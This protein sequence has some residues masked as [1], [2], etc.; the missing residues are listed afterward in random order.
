MVGPLLGLPWALEALG[1]LGAG[2]TVATGNELYKGYQNNEKD[3]QDR[4]NAKSYDQK[5]AEAKANAR[6][7]TFNEWTSNPANA[8]ADPAPYGRNMIG[9]PK[10]NPRADAKGRIG[11]M[12]ESG[13]YDFKFGDLD[14]LQKLDVLFK[15][16][17]NSTR[18]RMNNTRA[19]IGQKEIDWAA[20]DAAKAQ[21]LSIEQA[22]RAA[23]E[24]ERLKIREGY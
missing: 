12:Q 16:S 17:E 2:A 20:R 8:P 19:F 15:P 18:D 5:L 3:K 22:Q 24:A 13:N 14:F 21:A 7:Q 4:E 6:N 9:W 10:D 11:P 1:V 23:L